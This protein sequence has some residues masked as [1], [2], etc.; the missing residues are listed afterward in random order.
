ME[1]VSLIIREADDEEDTGLQMGM[2]RSH[3]ARDDKLG[4]GESL[5][6]IG[7]K[8]DEEEYAYFGLHV[9]MRF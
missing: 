3:S 2:K 8:I 7:R 1:S 9:N 6:S 4:Q 5:K